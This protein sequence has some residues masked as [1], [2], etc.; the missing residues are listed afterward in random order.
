MDNITS[1][2]A[3][4]PGTTKSAWVLYN[5]KEDRVVS[6]ETC[7]NELLLSFFHVSHGIEMFRPKKDVLLVVEKVTGYGK[8]VGETV[9][10]TCFNSGRLVQAWGGR[11]VMYPRRR[12][13]KVLLGKDKGGDSQVRAAVLAWFGGE[14]KAKGLKASPG[15]LFGMASHQWQACG[16][17]L[18]FSR[19]LRS[20]V[21]PPAVKP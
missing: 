11:F 20:N 9:F 3:V 15:P 10:E 8:P 7:E 18:A 12:V 5:I 13:K 14:K 19:E 2:L 17:A 16:L 6:F 4:D 21:A 1:V